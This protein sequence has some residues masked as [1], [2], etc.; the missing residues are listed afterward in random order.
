M[1]KN[2]WLRDNCEALQDSCLNIIVKD[3]KLIIL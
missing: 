1:K 3:V 2:F